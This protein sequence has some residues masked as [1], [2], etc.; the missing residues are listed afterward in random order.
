MNSV[1]ETITAAATPD[2]TRVQSFCA[3]AH[4]G[5]L[6]VAATATGRSPA[7][8]SRHV[9]AL[10]SELAVSLF[11]RRG[12]G[13]A[14]TET[15]VRLLEYADAIAAAGHRF[16]AAA[17]GQQD[18]LSGTVR[19][20]ASRG[21]AAGLLP[22]VLAALR[23]AQPDIEIELVVTDAT[24]NLLQREADIAV[25]MFRPEQANLITR[26]LGVLEFGAFASHAYLSERGE[27][28]SLA[29]LADHDLI[30]D[31]RDDQIRTS[32]E[33][34]G[35]PVRREM[36]RV[37]C[38]D[39]ATS[40]AL[41]LAGCGIGLTHVRR[42]RDEPRVRQVLSAVPPLTMPVWLTSHSELRTSARVRVVFDFLATT[43]AG[44]LKPAGG[45]CR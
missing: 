15:G 37:R 35:V 43:L 19:L 20:T 29:A 10:E 16:A 32:L 1:N 5:T 41:V 31:D 13:M 30:G 9:S 36:F 18:S 8:L 34:L 45:L 14:L 21:V 6:A 24:A 42:G 17:S 25:R 23:T 3:V 33:A 22:P 38:D 11:E 44:Q 26:H 28:G 27:P 12:D 4:A 2:L 7:T 39:S 40:W